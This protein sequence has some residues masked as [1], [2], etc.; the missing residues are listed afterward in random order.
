VTL[1]PA[2]PILHVDLD[3][4]YASVETQKD[5]SLAGRPVVVAGAGGRGVV[6]SASYE[7]RRFGVTSAM[8]AVR[9]RRLAPGAI[10]V[11]P[12]FES[13]RAYSN[14]FREILLAHTPLVEPL[15]LDE[16][17]LDVAGAVRLF[18]PPPAIAGRIREQ[19]RRELGFNCSVGVAPNK[20][21]AKLAS[22]QAKPDGLLHVRDGAV[23]EFLDPLPVGALWGAGERTVE[24]LGKLGVR[25][26]G[27][28]AA[29]PVA[30]LER[31]LGEAS[32]AHLSALSRGLDDRTVVPYEAP[33]SISHEETFERDLDDDG[34]IVREILG[35]SRR[36]AA[37]L[38]EDGYLARTVVLKVRLANFTTLTR[39][40]TL[41]EP[42]DLAAKVY[43]VATELYRA[44]PGARRRIRLLG[45]QATG[46][47]A[48]GAEQLALLR[49]ERWGDLERT[50][51]RI[52][53]RFGRG[54]TLPATL[55]DSE[56][57]Q[58]H[59]PRPPKAGR[60]AAPKPASDGSALHGEWPTIGGSDPPDGTTRK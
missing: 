5:S 55:L 11:P 49:G 8:P 43:A 60:E 14:R 21:L 16:A 25:T 42:T 56:R 10:F 26:V 44:L 13:Y 1:R 45:V 30:V 31:V 9:A 33:K 52:E 18:G 4:F 40:R 58:D 24:T 32:G 34:E 15:S 51:D 53:R 2:E 41:P 6:M 38:R 47:Q 17:F 29:L 54:A 12:D 7:A 36:V 27:E 22:T 50:V 35:L 37:R 46:L 48:A 20:F 57:R 28:L 59:G 39:S 23:Q 3:A 19:V